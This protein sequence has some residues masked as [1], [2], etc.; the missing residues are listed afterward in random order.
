M[1]KKKETQRQIKTHLEKLHFNSHLL[2]KSPLS[3]EEAHL[4]S[5]S[6]PHHPFLHH[7]VDLPAGPDRYQT[8]S[9]PL[10]PEESGVVFILGAD[11]SAWFLPLHTPSSLTNPI[12]DVQ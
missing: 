9:A 10:N 1:E 12:R 7:T 4:P 2:M 3:L 8:I 11:P 5:C 6:S